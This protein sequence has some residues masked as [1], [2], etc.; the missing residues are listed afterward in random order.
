[1]RLLK[2]YE[3]GIPAWAVFLPAYGGW[4]RPWLRK[5]TWLLFIAISLVSM[6]CGFYDLYKNVPYIKEVRAAAR[7]ARRCMAAVRRLMRGE[8]CACQRR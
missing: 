1:M 5:L 7:I 2:L 3:S 4:Y 6:A 8:G